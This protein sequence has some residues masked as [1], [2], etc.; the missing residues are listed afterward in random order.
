MLSAERDEATE[1]LAPV[2]C[3]AIWNAL[4][5]LKQAGQSIL[6]VDKNLNVLLRLADRHYVLE[7]GRVSWMGDR[8]AFKADTTAIA[9]YLGMG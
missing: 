8:A 4:E 6:V 5:Q 9:G 7:K 3:E 2:V 1:G